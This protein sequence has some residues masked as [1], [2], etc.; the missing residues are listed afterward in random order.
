LRD[1]SILAHEAEMTWTVLVQG[2]KEL[3]DPDLLTVATDGREHAKRVIRWLRT[4]IQHTAPEVLAVAVAP[5]AEVAASLPKGANRIASIPDPVWGP[6]AGGVAL[7]AVAAISLLAGRPLV[8]PSLGPT[9]ALVATEPAAPTSRAWNVVVGHAGGLLAGILAL[10]L[11]GAANVPTPFDDHVLDPSR[12]AA[13][14]AAIAMTILGGMLARGSHPPAAATTL[15]VTLGV[16]RTGTDVLNLAVGVVLIAL[17]GEGIR[18]VRL[19]RPSPAMR[20]APSNG[21][22]RRWVTRGEPVRPPA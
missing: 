6:L 17:A 12:A 3:H 21:R 13:C 18:R 16:I 8:F 19:H 15:L 10:L 4:Q 2:A 1:L 9:A 20:S 22:M 5:A 14:V 7:A 11:F